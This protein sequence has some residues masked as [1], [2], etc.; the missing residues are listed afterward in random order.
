[1][2]LYI[3]MLVG[4]YNHAVYIDMALALGN[5]KSSSCPG[6]WG[7]WLPFVVNINIVISQSLPAQVN[8]SLSWAPIKLNTLCLLKPDAWSALYKSTLMWKD[9]MHM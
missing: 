1:M 8:H 9:S 5:C 6:A 4:V 2:Y 3:C 7:L